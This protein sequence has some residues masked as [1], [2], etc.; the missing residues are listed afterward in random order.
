MIAHCRENKGKCI[1]SF[2]SD[3][4][5][6]DIETTG[7]SSTYDEIIEVAALRV[8][9]NAVVDSFQSLVKPLNEVDEYITELTGIT[10]EMLSFAPEP[11]SVIPSFRDFIGKDIVIGYNVNFDINFLYDYVENLSNTS[12]SN[13]FVDLMRIAKKSLPE[14]EHHRLTDVAQ[15]LKINCDGYH[16]ALSDCRITHECFCALREH[17]AIF[18]ID[19]FIE[20]FK[21]KDPDLRKIFSEKNEFDETHQLYGKICVFTGKLEKMT[22]VEAARLVADAGGSCENGVTKN[23]NF[24]I[25][26]N[27]DYCKSLKDDKS[28]KQKKAEEYK[29]KG[30][31]IEIIPEEVFYEMIDF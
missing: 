3:Y 22:R 29:L 28:N 14:L 17:I 13:D 30:L 9:D 24:L 21:Y 16:R 2:P 4:T 25:L 26:G 15:A 31:D 19:A 7:L 11:E 27:N 20:S 1:I 12:L 18:G 5:V 8:R 6:V 23:T 10:N